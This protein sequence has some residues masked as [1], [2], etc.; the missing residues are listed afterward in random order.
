[1][2]TTEILEKVLFDI[3]NIGGVE[4]SA[5]ASRDGLLIYS[6]ISHKSQAETFAA[7]SATMLGAAETATTELGKGIPDRII[8]ESKHGKL[9]ATGAGQ[10][11]LLIVMTEPDAGLGLILIEVEKASKKIKEILG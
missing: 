7:M 8:V 3:K 2:N 10:K 6:N 4:T 1:M 11:A 9:I 5:I